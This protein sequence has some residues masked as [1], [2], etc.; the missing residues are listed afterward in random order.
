MRYLVILAALGMAPL[1]I[2]AQEATARMLHADVIPFEQM[3]NA[4]S[5]AINVAINAMTQAIAT[6]AA[7]DKLYNPGGAGNDADGCKTIASTAAT[8]PSI[9]YGTCTSLATSHRSWRDCPTGYVMTGVESQGLT[10]GAKQ[11]YGTFRCCRLQ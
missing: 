3:L 6:C 1:S 10:T 2:M 9:D 8:P 11:W 4:H 5:N 7:K